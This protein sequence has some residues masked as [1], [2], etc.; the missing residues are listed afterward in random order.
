[1]DMR[2]SIPACKQEGPD[3]CWATGIAEMSYWYGVTAN[4]TAC[5]DVECKVVSVAENATCCPFS[6]HRGCGYDAE[7]VSGIVKAANAF[8][9]GHTFS[10]H[11]GALRESDLQ[12]RLMEGKPVMV[13]VMWQAPQSGGHA[14]LLSG[15][16]PGKNIFGQNITNYYLHDP[17]EKGDYKVLSYGAVA[18]YQTGA[19]GK[20]FQGRWTN[21]VL[22]QTS[23]DM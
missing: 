8:I 11:S 4:T 22:E 18:D 12:A 15:C 6:Q 13:I 3:W 23:A 2:S 17:L 10:A 20:I 9:P 14:L 7:Q 16:A 5:N 1:M 19:A 21:A